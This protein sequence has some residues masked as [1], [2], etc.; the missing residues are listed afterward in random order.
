MRNVKLTTVVLSSLVLSLAACA[1]EAMSPEPDRT[2]P[3]PPVEPKQIQSTPLP[4]TDA[5]EPSR[6]ASVDAGAP[7]SM[8]A[9]E[10]PDMDAGAPWGEAP[11]VDA[12]APPSDAGTPRKPPSPSPSPP[13]AG[14]CKLTKDAAGFFTRTAG[15]AT[16]VGYV[17]AAYS[18]KTPMRLV[19]GLHG[20]G[21]SALNFATWGVNPWDTR[22]T[23]THIGIAVGGET[24]ANHCWSVGADDDKVLAAIEDVATCF[25]IDRARVV[26][27]GF[28]SGG[29]LAYRVGLLH[30]DQFA[31][32]LIENSG[33]YAAGEMP[34]KLTAGAAWRVPIAHS[35]HTGDTVFP[36]AKVKA[37]WEV[38]RA[39]GLPLR[40]QELPGGHDGVGAEWATWLLPAAEGWA[41]PAP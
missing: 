13:P 10:A 6:E 11:N 32:I 21:D 22:A 36:L 8:D 37:D 3:P 9:G 39:A 24:G 31:G 17:P 18:G 4:P 27:G 25:W 20:C 35:A 34:T 14:A 30:A 7:P 5:G 33:L 29:Q 26:I 23:Q 28:S 15:A 40:T 19:V 12:G 2:T 16:Y 41:R 1:S 38:I